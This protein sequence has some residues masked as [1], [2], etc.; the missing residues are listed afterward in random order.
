V[1]DF[2]V[3]VPGI[4]AWVV[5]NA[6]ADPTLKASYKYDPE[7]NVLSAGSEQN[8]V[9]SITV[10]KADPRNPKLADKNIVRTYTTTVDLRN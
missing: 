8:V 10:S 6:G 1:I 3:W 2:K 7:A 5:P 4:P 9:I